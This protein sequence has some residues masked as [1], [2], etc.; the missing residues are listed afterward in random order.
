MS[1]SKPDHFL[2]VDDHPVLREGVA[3]VLRLR[4]DGA[5]T[6]QAAT[7]DEAIKL[8]GKKRLSAVIVEPHLGSFDA[9]T[10][11]SKLRKSIDAPIVAFAAEGN[12]RLLA[13]ALKSGARGCVRKD[14]SPDVL[15]DAINSVR[16]GK[17]YIDASL[18]SDGEPNLG[19]EA[20]ILTER[21]RQILQM[22]ADGA[23]TERVAETLGLSTE[24]VRT[25]T[26]RIL[27]KLNART[28]THAVAEAIRN[29]VID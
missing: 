3:S 17:F 4:F 20:R 21:Q 26:K 22:Y 13:E 9:T 19:E 16:E 27:A 6:T 11:I 18:A 5:E 8:V 14:S 29:Q 28:R 15:T 25:H 24:T 10:S 1:S 12:M 23:H 7:V 2:I